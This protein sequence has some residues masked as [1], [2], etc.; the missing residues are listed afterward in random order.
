MSL[1]SAKLE[2]LGLSAA[3]RALCRDL[4]RQM[5]LEVR[6][7]ESGHATSCGSDAALCLY[8]VAQEALN[9]CLKH[10]GATQVSVT[11]CQEPSRIWLRVVDDGQGLDPA[12]QRE[13]DSLHLGI[14]GMRE[15][16]RPWGGSLSLE[17]NP[18]G[19]TIVSAEIPLGGKR[20]RA[21]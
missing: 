13:Q 19:G 10:A 5:K 15:R 2:Y 1:H 4:S 16:L 21:A 3:L 6:F 20:D 11:L 7:S 14:L 18:S 9:N 12:A 8:R 17:G